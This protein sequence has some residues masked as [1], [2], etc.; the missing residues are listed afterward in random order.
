MSHEQSR[1]GLLRFSS[2]AA[3]SHS[4]QPPPSPSPPLHFPHSCASI[5]T[6]ATNTLP[7]W[8][9]RLRGQ[10]GVR[11]TLNNLSQSFPPTSGPPSTAGLPTPMFR[12]VPP[13]VPPLRVLLEAASSDA[14]DAADATRSPGLCGIHQGGLGKEQVASIPTPPCRPLLAAAMAGKPSPRSQFILCARHASPAVSPRAD[15]L[16]RTHR[17]RPSLP[18]RRSSPASPCL[19][20]VDINARK[21]SCKKTVSISSP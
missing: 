10:D 9:W 18:R 3:A 7:L 15:G 20:S 13:V 19:L 8:M 11:E 12:P 5:L 21:P 17:M 2:L 6:G 16:G 14:T 1:F 4:P